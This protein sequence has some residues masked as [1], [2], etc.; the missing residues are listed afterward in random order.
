MHWNYKPSLHETSESKILV[1]IDIKSGFK[2]AEKI[3]DLPSSISSN[4]PNSEY[5]DSRP[6]TGTTA[7]SLDT[8]ISTLS[9][10]LASPNLEK[11]LFTPR[12]YTALNQ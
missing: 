5:N 8:T 9:N 4:T 12:T 2:V 11:D 1:Q 6:S 7:T 10:N 3:N